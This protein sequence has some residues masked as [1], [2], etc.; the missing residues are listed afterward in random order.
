[1]FCQAWREERTILTQIVLRPCSLG[2]RPGWEP[3]GGGGIS[4]AG[5]RIIFSIV[6]SPPPL[7]PF[8]PSPE[9]PLCEF[10]GNP[11]QAT[12]QSSFLAP[13]TA[14]VSRLNRAGLTLPIV[15][16]CKACTDSGCMLRRR[17]DS[18]KNMNYYPKRCE[19]KSYVACLAGANTATP[20]LWNAMGRIMGRIM[21]R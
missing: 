3:G 15:H 2:T 14:G 20:L 16:S 17:R 1:M 8:P 19:Q 6:L 4:A 5:A 7:P 21:A 9:T 10:W 12:V 18:R 11:K 13:R